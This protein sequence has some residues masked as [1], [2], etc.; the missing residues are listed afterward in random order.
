MIIHKSQWL[1]RYKTLSEKLQTVIELT[2]TESFISRLTLLYFEKSVI[3]SDS[4]IWT[5][6]PHLYPTPNGKF[7]TRYTNHW[8]WILSFRIGD[9]FH[10]NVL[11]PVELFRRHYFWACSHTTDWI[12]VRLSFLLSCAVKRPGAMASACRS[13]KSLY[14]HACSVNIPQFHNCSRRRPNEAESNLYGTKK[15]FG[16]LNW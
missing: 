11:P 13:S 1:V 2:V 7:R 8:C 12:T 6:R 5:Y 14:V 4:P 10:T 15:G 16:R 9:S 3:G